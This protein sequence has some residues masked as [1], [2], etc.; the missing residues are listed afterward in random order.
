MKPEQE[1][2]WYR[3]GM[4]S[5]P[6]PVFFALAGMIAATAAQADEK[7]PPVL[8]GTANEDA[9]V[10]LPGPDEDA[11][12]DPPALAQAGEEGSSSRQATYSEV[13]ATSM[14]GALTGAGIPLAIAVGSLVF[15]VVTS[16]AAP[17][18]TWQLGAYV[19]AASLL[20]VPV[21]G[22]TGA[23]GVGVLVALLGEVPTWPLWADAAVGSAAVVLAGPVLLFATGLAFFTLIAEFASA[24]QVRTQF[25]AAGVAGTAAA[26]LVCIGIA[27]TPAFSLGAAVAGVG[28]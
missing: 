27:A 19:F 17:G 14:A 16:V 9:A 13:A 1:G 11:G 21:G 24:D 15:G 10:A 7:T 20:C 22:I 2:G 12:N 28:E 18:P 23:F 6:A 8:A 26:A 25:L 5:R 3:A 4:L